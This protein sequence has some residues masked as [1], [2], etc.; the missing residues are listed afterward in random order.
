MTNAKIGLLTQTKH[1][2]LRALVKR[3][4]KIPVG[5]RN[6]EQR[7]AIYLYKRWG[8]QF[9]I[10]Q[11]GQLTLD[12]K[13]VLKNGEETKIIKD[14]FSRNLGIAV[15][16]RYVKLKETYVGIS[17]RR[18]IDVLEAS[19]RYQQQRPRFLNKPQPK[20]ITAKVPGQRWQIDLIE[21]RKDAVISNGKTYNYILQVLDVYS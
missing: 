10:N 19:K 1:E 5:M 13:V 21:M 9:A 14:E 8:K 17:E 11:N 2:A 3:S 20:T 6:A 4:F 15:R 18:F 16:S 7:K 12:G